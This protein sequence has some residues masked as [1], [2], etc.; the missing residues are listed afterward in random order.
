MSENSTVYDTDNRNKND[1]DYYIS[2]A[3]NDIPDN[4]VYTFTEYDEECRCAIDGLFNN[5]V[6]LLH[7][8]HKEKSDMF[9]D[10]KSQKY[11]AKMEQITMCFFKVEH[12]IGLIKNPK[13]LADF[14]FLKKWERINY[15]REAVNYYYFLKLWEKH[16]K[17]TATN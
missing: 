1:L 9:Q 8:Q 15:C 11:L 16:N 6:D 12:V 3:D 7:L 13:F 10:M 2:H 5:F 4:N 14:E 17:N